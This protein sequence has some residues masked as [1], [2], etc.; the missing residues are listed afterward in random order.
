MA[1]VAEQVQ[2]VA[3]NTVKL[4]YVDQGYTG[5]NAA[6]AAEQHS[7]QLCAVK[8]PMAKRGFVLLPERWVVER[9][10]A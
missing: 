4:A 5:E 9:F 3:G 6:M 10:F 1:S 8:H 2:Q 7:I